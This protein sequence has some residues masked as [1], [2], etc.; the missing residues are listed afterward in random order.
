MQEINIS[1]EYDKVF[2][3]VERRKLAD[4]LKAPINRLSDDFKY[5]IVHFAW[6]AEMTF[7]SNDNGPTR[8]QT[9]ESLKDIEKRTQALLT[10]LSDLDLTSR[11]ALQEEAIRQ[12]GPY[13][14]AI[15]DS[16]APEFYSD[17]GKRR[18]FAWIV[19][20][21]QIHSSANRTSERFRKS[22][23]SANADRQWTVNELLKIWRTY[24][25]Q[26]PKLSYNRRTRRTTGP[27]LEFCEI[28]SGPAV[29][30]GGKAIN[31][32]RAIR[33]ELYGRVQ[34]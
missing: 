4:L 33:D 3:V 16:N 1:E 17:Y 30:A 5:D 18:Y 25:K 10:A 2:T 24:A 7:R 6:L 14:I 31:L 15:E 29:K 26:E 19:H 28:A 22:G 32:E 20:L 34:R 13:I 12:F 21:K 27:F 9:R 8:K 11:R 23:P